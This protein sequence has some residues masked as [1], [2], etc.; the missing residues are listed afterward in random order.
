MLL[1]K[2]LHHMT[3]IYKQ[4]REGLLALKKII[5]ILEKQLVC[6]NH[7]FILLLAMASSATSLDYQKHMFSNE[8]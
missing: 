8:R 5:K 2:L 6:V 4:T 1:P 7:S 3:G